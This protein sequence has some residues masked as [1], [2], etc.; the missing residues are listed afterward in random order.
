MGLIP[1]PP[2]KITG[3]EI[4]L[5]GKNIAKYTDKQMQKYVEKTLQ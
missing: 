4:L 5:D 3:G 1:S 2:G